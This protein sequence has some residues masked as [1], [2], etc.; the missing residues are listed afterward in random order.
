[1][2]FV[3]KHRH[4]AIAVAIFL[5][6]VGVFFAFW[7]LEASDGRTNSQSIYLNDVQQTQTAA[8]ADGVVR[9]QFTSEQ[10][11]HAI[12]IVPIFGEEARDA[13][14]ALSVYSLSGELLATAENLP[15]TL[16][17]GQYAVYTFAQEIV[18]GEYIMQVEYLGGSAGEVYLAKS[19]E[20]LDGWQLTQG[21]STDSGALCLLISTD[22]IGGFLTG[23]Y[24][25]FAVM[26][27][28][29]LTVLYCLMATKKDI[30]IHAL[31]AVAAGTLVLM[32]C[33]ILPP[34]AAPD[35]QFHINQA[36]NQSSQLLGQAPANVDWGYNYKR[37]DDHNDVVQDRITSMHTYREISQQFFTRS[38][39]DT[40]T[41]YEQEE[42]GG[43][44]TLYWPSAI[45]V[46]ICRLLGLGFVPTL[47]AGRLVN[48]ALFV[49]LSTMAVKIA[50]AGKSIFAAVGLLPMTMHLAASF[51][52]DALSIGLFLF[53]T[54][55][56]LY[57]ALEK[58]NIRLPD[59]L[60][61]AAIAFAA[62]P[63]KQ[64][65]APLLLMC[66]LIPSAKFIFKGRA[67][68]K[69]GVIAVKCGIVLCGS[70]AFINVILNMVLGAPA[71]LD[72]VPN[73]V[74]DSIPLA[75]QI[76]YTLHD[77]LTRPF[78]IALL[79]LRTLVE[80]GLTWVQQM[81]GGSLSYF[82]LNISWGFVLVLVVLLVVAIIPEPDEKRL[83]MRSRLWLTPVA[84]GTIAL[85]ILACLLWTPTYY[86]TLYGVQGRYFLPA[87][88]LL[89]CC[90]S[91]NPLGIKKTKNTTRWLIFA[92]AATGA[93]ALLNAL[94]LII[95]R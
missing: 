45:A 64:V 94:L 58:Q 10:A 77:I 81:V 91:A 88:P 95:Q 21:G 32:F 61:L 3:K 66:F 22:M 73:V 4:L 38:A 15:N 7:V 12:G 19:N 51:S 27:S 17:S 75:D 62:G 30:S 39:D 52:R 57:Y 56:C 80:Q 89:L 37:A 74:I 41:Q 23:F 65:Y 31:Y 43:A 79:L 85:A 54:A 29:F 5:I 46:T 55:L 76:V 84:L 28:A 36:F 42:V 24:W 11:F 87:L 2:L 82:N 33:F 60:L 68:P 25:L 69:L 72:A 47:Y 44:E 40:I 92:F 16:V 83:A 78:Y 71:Q 35:E 93:F 90:I 59:I 8:L 6:C 50:P 20:T 13:H 49:W 48:M 34:Y 53:F 1:M 14:L 67:L 86:E 70:G 18:Q 26:V 9:Q 63:T